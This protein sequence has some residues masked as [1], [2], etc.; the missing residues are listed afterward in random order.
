MTGLPSRWHEVRSSDGA[1]LYWRR[2]GSGYEVHPDDHQ[3]R[4]ELDG[5]LIDVAP[6]LTTAIVLC[7]EHMHANNHQEIQP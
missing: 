7:R 3:F 2:E 4:C 1:L 6:T 5:V